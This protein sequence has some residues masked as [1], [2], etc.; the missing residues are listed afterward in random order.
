MI[1]VIWMSPWN[2]YFKNSE[3]AYLLKQTVQRFGKAIVL[4]ADEPAINTY[5]AMWYNFGKARNK[6]ILKWNNIKNRVKSVLWKIW[7]D[8]SVI[9][10][11]DWSRD[12]KSNI[13]YQR[14]YNGIIHLYK[15]ND[16]FFDKINE[17]SQSVLLSSWKEISSDSIELATHYILS[18]FAFLEYCYN[19][20]DNEKIAYIY[21]KNW[22][23][24]EDYIAGI[25]DGIVRPHLEFILLEHPYEKYISLQQKISRFWA[26]K[27][28][29]NIKTIFSP[30]FDIFYDKWNNEYGWLFYEILRKTF[31]DY[32]I[33]VNIIGQASYGFFEDRLN[34]W[35]ADIFCSPVWPTKRRRLDVFFSE[36]VFKSN[37]YSYMRTD[38][39]YTHFSFSDLQKKKNLRIAVKEDDIH[40]DIAKDLFPYAR[41]VWVPQLSSI[42]TV[43][44]F[45]KD[46]RADI[47]FWDED[48]VNKYIENNN[49]PSNIFTKKSQQDGPIVTYDNCYALPWWE[50][51]LQDIVNEWI[52]KY[53]LLK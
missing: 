35:F 31:S 22:R 6:A 24:Y 45:V 2:S 23:V 8:P 20:F 33:D 5:I 37:I 42:E 32:S 11:I 38:S 30:Y 26:I 52:K 36:S 13:N 1:P 50:F 7:I 16:L 49:L 28:R 15:N 41:L 43:L 25:F 39:Q 4:V 53:S 18:E 44:E 51:E 17:T 12:I 10:I 29:K 34:T 46:N 14:H 40:H 9:T 19:Y 48:L 47:T 27:K 3:V 21:H